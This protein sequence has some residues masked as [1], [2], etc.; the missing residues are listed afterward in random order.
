VNDKILKKL[1]K[2]EISILRWGTRFEEAFNKVG[3]EIEN[4]EPKI[5]SFDYE[6]LD[7]V[8]DELEVPA[9]SCS[10]PRD[11]YNDVYYNFLMDP[12]DD[13]YDALL[14]DFKKIKKTKETNEKKKRVRKQ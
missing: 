9:D 4:F 1:L 11:D 8:L 12:D 14:K 3:I 2:Y 6:I 7:L 5:P 13:D 10:T